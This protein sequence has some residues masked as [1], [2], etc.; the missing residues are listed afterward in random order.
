MEKKQAST[1][2]HIF[3][4]IALAA[5]VA[6][7]NG[8]AN[9]VQD[10]YFDLWSKLGVEKREILVDRVEDARETQ[11]EAQEEFSS[12][13]E[14]FSTLINFDGG[15][16]ED[17]YEELNDKYEDSAS[18]AQKVTDRINRV[19]SVAQSLF[20][21]WE[22]ELGLISNANLRRDSQGKLDNTKR[23]YDS[24]LKAMRRAEQSMQPVITALRD[25]VLYLKHNLNA[26]A[27]GGLQGELSTIKKD[28]D[29]LINRM[30]AAIKES[31]EF[32]ANIQN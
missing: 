12:A 20:R 21:E 19:E 9:A 31:D 3:R 26:S 29:A 17:V 16:L 6:L 27:I 30:N 10:A 22:D 24:L 11:Q 28:V 32:I 15:E 1:A 8:C 7:T 23:Q 5:L 25:N 13:L 14:E 2:T 18:A 4:V